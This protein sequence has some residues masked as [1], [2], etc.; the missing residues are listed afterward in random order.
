MA[1]VLVLLPAC[2][3]APSPEQ[4]IRALMQR[5]ER[6]AEDGDLDGLMAVVS[7]D[8]RDDD[9]R[10]RA[11]LRGIVAFYLRQTEEL[12]V[13]YQEKRLDLDGPDDGT[14][15][16]VVALASRPLGSGLDLREISADLLRVRVRLERRDGEFAL[17]GATW[18]PATIADFVLDPG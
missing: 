15:E 10:D 1:L 14:V 2:P 17:V 16:A 4:Q 9:G 7:P 18:E 6:A 11:A 3:G 13:L 12:H 8:Y 5:A